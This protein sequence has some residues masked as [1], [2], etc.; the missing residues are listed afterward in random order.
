MSGRAET[1]AR[2]GSAG[3]APGG[4][5]PEALG[6]DAV[7]ALSQREVMSDAELARNVARLKGRDLHDVLE[8]IRLEQPACLSFDVQHHYWSFDAAGLSAFVGNKLRKMVAKRLPQLLAAAVAAAGNHA[9][10]GV[11][12]GRA[13][14][15]AAASSDSS[16]PVAPGSPYAPP[17]PASESL[18]RSQSLN[19][20]QSLGLTLSPGRSLS[21][22]SNDAPTPGPPDSAQRGA[23]RRRSD[24]AA[25][26]AAARPWPNPEGLALSAGR[27]PRS[28]GATRAEDLESRS[29][30]D[31]AG[32]ASQDERDGQPATGAASSLGPAQ[33]GA[34]APPAKKRRQSR[35]RPAAVTSPEQVALMPVSEV[36]SGIKVHVR[37][38]G[39]QLCGQC[40]KWAPKR[41]DM[42]NHIRTHT[43]EK[44]LECAACGLRFAH[45]SNLHAHQRAL[46]RP[47]RA[48]KGRPGPE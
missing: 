13:P 7:E 47:K 43:G 18:S 37:D 31:A 29:S 1:L 10:S 8:M 45:S 40:F 44:P 35:V 15:Q 36:I 9:L 20:S 33:P 3:S 5:V 23:R 34:S 16:L 22:N 28:D 11:A 32:A 14:L 30:T 4:L 26:A 39:W 17:P 27:G 2:S 38:D 24:P 12:L 42:V 19:S 46:H 25:A 48:K 41:S 21:Q 6:P